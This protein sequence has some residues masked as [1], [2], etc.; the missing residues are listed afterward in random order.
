VALKPSLIMVVMTP[1]SLVN[2]RILIQKLSYISAKKYTR[3]SW[4]IQLPH[5]AKI[6]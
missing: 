3:D 5:F 4:F 6:Y 2:R 1:D